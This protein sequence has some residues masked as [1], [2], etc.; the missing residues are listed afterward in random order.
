MIL[1]GRTAVVTGGGR[2]IGRAV[3]L[4]L[5]ERGAR[6]A[7]AAR[8]AEEIG[9]VAREITA[10]G[11]EARAIRCDVARADDVRELFRAVAVELGPVDCLVND[12]GL[13]LRKPLVDTEEAEWDRI[14]DVNLKG[15]Y[16][17]CRAALGGPSGMLARKGGR[18][19]NVGSISGTLGTPGLAAYCASKWG[20][21][22]LTKALAEEL[23]EREILVAAVLPGSVDTD[24]LRG[25]GFAPAMQPEAVAKV[26]AFLCGEAPF[27]ITGSGVEVFG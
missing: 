3:A 9:A 27:A 18:I 6:V 16:L 8:T 5:A 10:R 12:A 14:L 22:G 20:L 17:C 2:G 4:A 11:G 15:A 24:M 23:R 26:V 25:S 21:T 7:V 1:A 19:V 13:V